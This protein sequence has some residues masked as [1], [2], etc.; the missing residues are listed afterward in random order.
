M[1]VL[2][3]EQI[4][5]AD[6]YTIENEPIASIDLMERASTS[7]VEIFYQNHDPKDRIAVVCG[8]GN[9]GGDGLAIS[10]ILINKGYQVQPYV[11]QI[12][13]GGSDDFKTNF[14]RLDSIA[15]IKIISDSENIPDFTEYKT[16]IDALFG[17]GLTRAVTGL[18]AEVIN[19]I[20]DNTGA[21]V[22]SVDIASGLFVDR[23]NE[24]DEQ[25]A[26][27]NAN[28]TISF[29][30]PKLSFFI[31]E[32]FQYVGHWKVLDIGLMQD[33][34]NQQESDYS[35]IEQSVVEKILPQRSKFAHKGSFGHGQIISGSYGKMGAATL[36]A[37]AFMRTGAGLLTVTVP[38]SGVTIMQTNVPEAMVLEQP[39]ERYISEFNISP[40]ADTYGIGP[41]IG[42][43]KTTASAFAKFLRDNSKP[44]VLDADA[45]N[46]L[47]ANREM[48]SLLPE[49]T[50]I[51]PH[52]RE[53]DRLAGASDNNW[54]RLDKAREFC[55]QWHLITVL[56]GAHTAVI[57]KDGKVLFNI[58]GNPG[59]ATGG[60]GDVLLGIIA[61]LRAQGLKGIDAA[62]AGTFIHGRAGD[63][64][65]ENKSMSS[66]LAGDIIEALSTVFL[67]FSR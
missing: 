12:K 32:N 10:R 49:D 39:G 11:V 22:I 66:L 58:T 19:K 38:A 40:K 44:L 30:L 14:D 37:E 62:T 45:L 8:T 47:S 36:A 42:Q 48:L 20:N 56:K 4:R 28:S 55:Q 31:P 52:I 17:S 5:L 24:T 61:S 46:I 35:T 60:S 25:G 16:I 53:F 18:Y 34:I 1:I 63:V 50:I 15:P 9:N 26:I 43:D 57:N 64:A 23:P 27:I 51:T 7:F 29:Q 67:G 3:A 41:G 21:E 6:A 54:Q 65:A 2:N 59:M 13:E 33:F